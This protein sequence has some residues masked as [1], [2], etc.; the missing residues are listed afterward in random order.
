ME[1]AGKRFMVAVDISTSLSSVVKGT[2]VSTAVAAAAMAM[3]SQRT[4]SG[5]PKQ[6]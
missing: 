5:T 1:P 4:M 6:G 3:V 2:A